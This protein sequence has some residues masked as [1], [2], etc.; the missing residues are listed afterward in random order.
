MRSERI[1]FRLAETEG[2]LLIH[3]T[4]RQRAYM[5][6]HRAV[7]QNAFLRYKFHMTRITVLEFTIILISKK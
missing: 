1:G 2:N 6:V 3:S 4:G 7:I 5:Y